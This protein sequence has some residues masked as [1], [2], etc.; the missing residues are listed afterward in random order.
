M[1]PNRYQNAGEGSITSYD[2][3]DIADGTGIILLYGGLNSQSIKFSIGADYFISGA[4]IF[5]NTFRSTDIETTK[6]VTGADALHLN[7]SFE[8]AKFN[9]PRIVRGTVYA[10]IPTRKNAI[11]IPAD[12]DYLNYVMLQKVDGITSAVTNLNAEASGSWW[13]PEL[14]GCDFI[15]MNISGSHNFKRGDKLR[16]NLRGV[17]GGGAA[18]QAVTIGHDPMNRNGTWLKP[19]INTTQTTQL[20]VWVPFKI[21]L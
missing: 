1:I 19:S 15:K 10:E 12:V 4:S 7:I 20:K 2:Y 11:V 13:T 8:L 3:I 18:G 6:T 9:M 21:D 5:Q 16:L 17:A 14:S